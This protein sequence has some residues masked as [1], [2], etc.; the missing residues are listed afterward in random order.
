MPPNKFCVATLFIP[1]LLLVL[2]TG[3]AKAQ[4]GS[5]LN[6]SHTPQARSQEE[7]D[8]YLDIFTSLD[9][10]ETIGKVNDFSPRYPESEL[11]GMTFQHQMDAYQ[12]LPDFQ[13]IVQAGRRVLQFYPDHLNALLTVS[14]AIPSLLTGDSG[15]DS[16]L[17]MEAENYAARGLR[18]IEK[19][20]IS[21]EIPLE[22]WELLS[23]QMKAQAHEAL[24]LVAIKRGR[25]DT[26]ISEFETAASGNPTPQGTQFY[27]LGVTYASAHRYDQAREALRRAADLGPERIRALAQ[28]QLERLSSGQPP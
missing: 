5:L 28:S 16:L 15:Q 10:R 24:G 4:L 13:G 25:L 26:A 27:Y 12:K 17:L 19:M 6:P 11:L 22:R 8:A 21:Q 9:P 2:M 23:G 20:R 18:E 14:L 3:G 1:I 7:L